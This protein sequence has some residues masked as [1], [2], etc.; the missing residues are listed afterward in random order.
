MP[1]TPL[2]TFTQ[3]FLLQLKE[4]SDVVGYSFEQC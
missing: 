1:S 4:V 2:T 3:P